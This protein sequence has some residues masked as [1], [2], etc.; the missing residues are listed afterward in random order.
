[1][2]DVVQNSILNKKSILDMINNFYKD[3]KKCKIDVEYQKILD[4]TKK[5]YEAIIF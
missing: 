1:M 2:G 4:N 3:D 5:F